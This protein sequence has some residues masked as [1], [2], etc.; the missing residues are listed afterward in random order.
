METLE[1]MF[2]SS[3]HLEII[4]LFYGNPG[5]FANISKLAKK[6][7]KSH[8]TVRKAIVDLVNAGIL[9]ELNI[10]K[11]RVIKINEK[12]PYTEI[13]F[14]FIN[15]VRSVKEKRSIEEII[16]KRAGVPSRT[17]GL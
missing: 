15:T 2:G 1:K 12:S 17:G 6:L 11:S 3:T 14:N 13:L 5:Y 10:G 8:V 9:T 7:D 4:L 16:A